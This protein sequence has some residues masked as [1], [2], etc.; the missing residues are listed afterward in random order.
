MIFASSYDALGN[1]ATIFL[2]FILIAQGRVYHQLQISLYYSYLILAHIC[3]AFNLAES[4][5]YEKDRKEK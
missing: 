3:L 1:K 4:F 2:D 5:R